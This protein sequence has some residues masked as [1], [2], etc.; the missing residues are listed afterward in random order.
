MSLP[1]LC[2]ALLDF[3]LCKLGELGHF[4]NSLLVFF[5]LVSG[6]LRQLFIRKLLFFLTELLLGC[7]DLALAVTRLG[8]LLLLAFCLLLLEG[9]AGGHVTL[10]D[11][12]YF[13]DQRL[14]IF[15]RAA[16]VEHGEQVLHGFGLVQVLLLILLGLLSDLLDFDLSELDL[17]ELALFLLG[18]LDDRREVALADLA[19]DELLL[20]AHRVLTS[21]QLACLRIELLLF[22]VAL[23]EQVFV[24]DF[25]RLRR[26]LL[27]LLA[28]RLGQVVDDLLV[29]VLE[30]AR[31]IDLG[32]Q[33]LDHLLLNIARHD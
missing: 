7:H 13:F 28:V 9:L 3:F 15:L 32:V 26:H 30:L 12:G 17:V 21:A 5:S 33:V 14:R 6:S 24:D 27:L 29:P 18:L 8:L 22:V 23:L 19:V 11:H 31:L 1:K 20:D 2:L 16:A 4:F 10:F 25:D